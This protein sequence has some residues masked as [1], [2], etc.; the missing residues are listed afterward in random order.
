MADTTPHWPSYDRPRVGVG[1]DVSQE[2]LAT[3]LQNNLTPD[4]LNAITP[5]IRSALDTGFQIAGDL[6]PAYNLIDKVASGQTPSPQDAVAGLAGAATAINPLAGAAVLA[7]GEIALGAQQ[8]VE[9]LLKGLGLISDAPK[10]VACVGLLKK[11]SPVPSGGPGSLHP[12]PLWM[13][14]NDFARWWYPPSG[15]TD[16]GWA[17]G[18][19][20]PPR[21]LSPGEGCTPTAGA[22][23]VD[24]I[25]HGLWYTSPNHDQHP[26]S[27]RDTGLV[28]TP[29]PANAFEAFLLPMMQKDIENWA[30]ANPYIDPRALVL[31]AMKAWNNK[32]PSSSSDIT[33]APT[34]YGDANGNW[35]TMLLGSNGD[36]TGN[37]QRVGSQVVQMGASV[38]TATAPRVVSL[39]IGT[40][41]EA[42]TAPTTSTATK[43]VAGSAIAVGA[44]IA[45]AAIYSYVKGEAISAVLKHLWRKVF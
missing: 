42:A 2:D 37:A 21:G 44:G 34:E 43:V 28:I 41:G 4:A 33:Y 9:D 3:L 16:Y 10:P 15:A 13:V 29:T 12:D 6:T 26:G 14:W 20:P 45:G 5:S 27:S 8:A 38:P 36:S 40:H 23:V 1:A 7:A 11:G 18:S 24:M 32:H 30:N 25:M 31:A 35:I 22:A 19:A 17:P 39:H